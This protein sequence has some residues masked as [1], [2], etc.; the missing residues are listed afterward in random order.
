MSKK[1]R[2]AVSVKQIRTIY[3]GH[4]ALRQY[5]VA[6]EY[7]DGSISDVFQ[8]ECFEK[9]HVAGVL[10]YDVAQDKV[11][12]VEQFR[13]GALADPHSP[14]QIEIVAGIVDK[15]GESIAEMAAREL[16]EETG[17]VATALE[18]IY[19]Y[20]VS[21]GGCN[22]QVSLFWADVDSSQAPAFCGLRAEHEDIRVRVVPYEEAWAMMQQGVIRNSLTIIALQW[23]ALHK[24]RTKK[25][26]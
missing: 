13:I 20:W 6:I 23:L 5:D 3:E 4:S 2:D 7:Y 22:E 17:L 25:G 26:S 19:D 15:A 9:H 18:P 21:P 14:W 24:E 1:T 12:L 16:Q 8:R 10:P 11:V